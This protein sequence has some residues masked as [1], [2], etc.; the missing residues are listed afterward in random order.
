MVAAAITATMGRR[1]RRSAAGRAARPA[2][3]VARA[4][5]VQL[6]RRRAHR[7]M[8]HPSVR[9]TTRLLPATTQQTTGGDTRT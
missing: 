2:G 4:G 5:P 6:R 9:R 3:P 1:R 8:R 7:A